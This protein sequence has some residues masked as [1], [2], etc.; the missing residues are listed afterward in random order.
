MT[1]VTKKRIV[2]IEPIGDPRFK[3]W[4]KSLEGVDQTIPDGFAFLGSFVRLN[5]KAELPV[6]TL[7]LFF[8]MEGSR[9][10]QRPC[11]AL[12]VV[13]DD[14]LETLYERDE[15]DQA[16]AL[17]VR[18]D[19]ARIVA[20]RR[21]PGPAAAGESAGSGAPTSL[22]QDAAPAP[23]GDLQR[24]AQRLVRANGDLL[25]FAA[26]A[27]RDAGGAAWR[28]RRDAAWSD[29]TGDEDRQTHG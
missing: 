23:V 29:G 21:R 3:Q 5:R 26:D 15:L 16:W 1:D 12:K 2:F 4:V 18:D 11:V 22:H 13:T 14:G 20:A 19:I 28:R 27:D 24:P 17:D 25:A 9:K 7:L 10:R 6:G 8:G